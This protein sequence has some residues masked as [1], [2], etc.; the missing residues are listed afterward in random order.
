MLLKLTKYGKAE[1]N[2]IQHG[3]VIKL[4]YSENSAHLSFDIMKNEIYLKDSGD[5]C[6]DGLWEIR[7]HESSQNI[8]LVNYLYK[9]LLG[10]KNGVIE[11]VDDFGKRLRLKPIDEN[12]QS[13]ENQ[14]LI[15]L[16][17]ESYNVTKT[18][19]LYKKH[20]NKLL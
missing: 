6:Y 16:S 12:K 14:D 3:D 17:Y 10:V 20:E 4:R 9:N 11:L 7:Y 15:N 8:Y 1:A 18:D 19:R 2:K 13:I 5:R